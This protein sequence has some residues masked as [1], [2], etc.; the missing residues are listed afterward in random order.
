MPLRNHAG[1]QLNT[2]S[3]PFL[4]IKILSLCQH[5]HV[6]R[7]HDSPPPGTVHQPIVEIFKAFD[8]LLLLKRGG[9]TIFNGALGRESSLLVSYFEAVPGVARHPRGVNPANWMLEVTGMSEE[10]R[11]GVD[12]SEIFEG[13][14]VAR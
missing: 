2:F 11:L 7:L 13:S 4:P 5:C 8:D 12:F 9:Y 14:S 10:A 3:M 6:I 1:W